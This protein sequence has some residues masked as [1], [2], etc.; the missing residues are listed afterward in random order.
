[1]PARRI[2]RDVNEAAR[3]VARALAKTE[4][5]ARSRRDRKK[6]EMLFAHL[7]RILRLGRLRL[8]RPSGARFG[9]TLA[10]I[11][12]NL[13][14]LAKLVLAHH[15]SRP[16]CAWTKRCGVFHRRNA[17]ALPGMR[18]ERMDASSPQKGAA[19]INA[20]IKSDFCNNIDCSNLPRCRLFGPLLG[21]RGQPRTA[22]DF[23][24]A[25]LG[26]CPQF[27][28]ALPARFPA[29]RPNTEP[30]ISPVPPG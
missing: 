30:A 4:A 14:R 28:P 15:R 9:F 22:M 3:D 8:R 13:K 21:A 23:K 12:Q 6:V 2:V 29:M 24:D 18:A 7:K 26:R 17:D 20:H 19:P 27:L 5:F 1:M 25:V 10:A 11:A 16:L